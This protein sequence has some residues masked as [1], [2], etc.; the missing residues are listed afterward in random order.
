MGLHDGECVIAIEGLFSGQKLIQDY[1]ARINVRTRMKLNI[2]LE[3]K[4]SNIHQ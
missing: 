3:E 4:C 2:I 1:A